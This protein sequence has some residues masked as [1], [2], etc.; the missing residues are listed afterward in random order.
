MNVTHCRGSDAIVAS[1]SSKSALILSRSALRSSAACAALLCSALLGPVL[2][3]LVLRCLVL[4]WAATVGPSCPRRCGGGQAGG[5]RPQPA[6]RRVVG[7]ARTSRY[8][9]GGSVCDG[10]WRR[11]VAT[12]S[13]GWWCGCSSPRSPTGDRHDA[14]AVAGG[15]PAGRITSLVSGAAVRRAARRARTGRHQ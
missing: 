13:A 2:R 3:W 11:L 4:G 6:R 12:G 15:S 14:G 5:A 8:Y 7:T 9:S 1:R 10:V